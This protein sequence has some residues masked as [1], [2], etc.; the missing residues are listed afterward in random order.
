[1][2]ITYDKSLKQRV[3]QAVLP[4]LYNDMCPFCGTVITGKNFA[5]AAWV[6]QEFRAFDGN[7]VCLIS[8]SDVLLPERSSDENTE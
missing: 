7:I 4:K 2:N 6:D 3:F 1:M 8:L 5:G